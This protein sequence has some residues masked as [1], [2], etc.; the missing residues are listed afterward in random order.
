MDNQQKGKYHNDYSPRYQKSYDIY[1]KAKNHM[2]KKRKEERS[3]RLPL[4]EQKHGEGCENDDTV[5]H[6]AEGIGNLSKK[7]KP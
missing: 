1:E 7:E 6:E 2:K 5:S 3:V 4:V